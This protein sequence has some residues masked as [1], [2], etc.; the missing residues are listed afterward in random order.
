MVIPPKLQRTRRNNVVGLLLS[1][2]LERMEKKS[3]QPI[4]LALGLRL[5]SYSTWRATVI[6]IVDSKS[7][8]W[9][10]GSNCG[11]VESKFVGR[12]IGYMICN[13]H[14]IAFRDKDKQIGLQTRTRLASDTAYTARQLLLVVSGREGDESQCK[15]VC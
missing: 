8:I 10:G 14:A 11:N 6:E 12:K 4:T 3:K 13:G 2:Q 1:I 7:G 5:L 15:V 9:S